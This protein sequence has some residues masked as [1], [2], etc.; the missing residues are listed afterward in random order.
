MAMEWV[1]AAV[2]IFA[3]AVAAVGLYLGNRDPSTR[4][5]KPSISGLFLLG[6]NSL[7]PKHGPDKDA[8]DGGPR[9]S[10]S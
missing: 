2:L 6:R 10:K 4:S 8:N 7:R 3:G 5:Y 1:V 9:A